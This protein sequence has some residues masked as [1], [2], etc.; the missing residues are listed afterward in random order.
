[1]FTPRSATRA[2]LMRI[3]WVVYDPISRE[4]FHSH[5]EIPPAL[6]ALLAPGLK[7]YISQGEGIGAVAPALSIPHVFRGRQVVQ[8][9]DNTV[10][11]SALINGYASKPDMARIVNVYHLTQFFLRSTVWLEWVPSKANIADLPSRLAYDDFFQ[12]LPRSRWVATVLPPVSVWFGPFRALATR[13]ERML[14]R[15]QG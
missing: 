13:V 14:N 12:I 4:A 5:F 6:F 1:M 9:N 3:G 8:F 7:T 15:R 2:Q 11:L 10:A